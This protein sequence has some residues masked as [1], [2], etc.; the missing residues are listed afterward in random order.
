MSAGRQQRDLEARAVTARGGL[1]PVP[2]RVPVDPE[3][4]AQTQ[5]RAVDARTPGI[6]T[7]SIAGRIDAYEGRPDSSVRHDLTASGSGGSSKGRFNRGLTVRCP[8]WCLALCWNAPHLARIE[9]WD[10][11]EVARNVA[12]HSDKRLLPLHSPLSE[13]GGGGFDPKWPT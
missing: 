1:D 8:N 4:V 13:T 12:R 7:R 5:V 10:S 6:S 11:R 2:K 9:V 3:W